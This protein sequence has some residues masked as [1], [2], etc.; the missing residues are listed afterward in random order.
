MDSNSAMTSQ[1]SMSAGFENEDEGRTPKANLR[2]E[3]II[4]TRPQ[5]VVGSAAADAR[6][7]TTIPEQTSQYSETTSMQHAFSMEWQNSQIGSPEKL[8]GGES[9][10][11]LGSLSQI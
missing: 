9:S 3:R 2:Q 8:K 11:N 6:S 1:L 10:L 4:N 5:L 7:L